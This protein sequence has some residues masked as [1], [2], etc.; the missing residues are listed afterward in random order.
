MYYN[1]GMIKITSLFFE[2]KYFTSR[3]PHHDMSGRI[4]SDIYSGNLSNI[5]SDIPPGILSGILPD[6][7]CDIYSAIPSGSQIF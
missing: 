3:D 6:I 1:V 2:K 5:Y 4:L 7:Y